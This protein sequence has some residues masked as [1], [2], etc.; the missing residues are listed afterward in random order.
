MFPILNTQ[1]CKRGFEMPSIDGKLLRI[2]LCR[3]LM[4]VGFK[5]EKKMEQ[6]KF[7]KSSLQDLADVYN[8]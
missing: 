5:A 2:E 8:L 4:A 7:G 1:S 3:S 6:K